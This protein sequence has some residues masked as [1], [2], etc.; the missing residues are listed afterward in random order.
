MID[1]QI[2]PPDPAQRPLR[3]AIAH[4]WLVGYRGGEMVLDAIIRHLLSDQH[5]L[6]RIY[7]M[8]DQGNPLSP[9]IDDLPRTVSPL[10]RYPPSLRRWLLPRYPHAVRELSRQLL[11]DHTSEPIDLLISTS[12]AAIKSLQPPP[13]IP[14]LCY[15]HSPARYLWSQTDNYRSRDLKGRLRALGLGRFAPGLRAWDRHTAS[16]VT[17]FIANSTHTAREIERCYNRES[18]VIHPPVRTDFFTPGSSAQRR[19]H[20]LLVSA[21]EP[22]KRIDLAI[23]AARMLDRELVIVG[24]GS[25]EHALRRHA[26]SAPGISF[27]GRVSDEQLRD[28]YRAAHAFLFPQ[29][30]DFGITAVEAQ[31]C[32]TPVV[33]RHEGGA[34]DSVIDAST[35]SFF[36]APTAESLA[37]AIDR[38]PPTDADSKGPCRTN[39]LRF[40]PDVFHERMR[41]AIDDCRRV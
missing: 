3:V 39:A 34:L 24:S 11:S 26:A 40:N 7:T 18:V 2:S 35:G 9:A 30:E 32:G 27:V 14:H 16:H 37:E 41:H 22:Y 20:L 19:D 13:G 10:D 12:S 21:L 29:I 38:C 31:A 1:P 23:D 8:F 4:D 36:H 25:H 6:T 15:C 33:A 17:R 28:H 5:T